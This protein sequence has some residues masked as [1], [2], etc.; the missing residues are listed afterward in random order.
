MKPYLFILCLFIAV[1][2][3]HAQQ[4][5]TMKTYE[6]ITAP[7]NDYQLT[8]YSYNYL[9]DVENAVPFIDPYDNF[10]VTEPKVS[11]EWETYEYTTGQQY[12]T[13]QLLY[14]DAGHQT[15][16]GSDGWNN[17]TVY[18]NGLK[19]FFIFPGCFPHELM[20]YDY[21]YTNGINDTVFHFSCTSGGDS[22]LV[23]FFKI[24]ANP[25]QP[26]LRDSQ[27]YYKYNEF[28][29]PLL[30]AKYKCSYDNQF[31]LISYVAED[32]NL[33]GYLINTTSKLYTYDG[34]NHVSSVEYLETDINSHSITNA[35]YNESGQMD[36]T[37]T[38]YLDPYN[39]G[40]NYWVKYVYNKYGNISQEISHVTWDGGGNTVTQTFYYNGE[41]TA[42]LS[43]E[44]N[45]DNAALNIYPNPSSGIITLSYS[46]QDKNN[47]FVIVNSVGIVMLKGKL[48][49]SG[50]STID[51]S[52]MATGIYFVQIEGKIATKFIKN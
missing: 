16:Y 42:I 30:N 44:E 34:D 45:Q 46:L 9:Q 1:S 33:A 18:E 50:M 20:V 43:L 36:S 12:E 7:T 35:F 23:G 48:N 3:I 4:K 40:Y 21:R 38:H 14:D 41:E 5:L 8:I 6:V 47:E 11:Q 19:R 15:F 25:Y 31:N 39:V 51:V 49:E 22:I 52:N 27:V 13:I 24:Y 10:R 2:Q 29:G 28:Q 37:R 26:E 32:Y 17:T